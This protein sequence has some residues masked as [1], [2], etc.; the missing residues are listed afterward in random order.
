MKLYS[1]AALF[2][3]SLPPKC[4]GGLRVPETHEA[5]QALKNRE[6]ESPS[7]EPK[8]LAAPSPCEPGRAY[9]EGTCI[10]EFVK[11]VPKLTQD[12]IKRVMDWIKYKV[13]QVKNPFCW[14]GAYN[15]GPGVGG[16]TCSVSRERI[17]DLCYPTCPSGYVRSGVDC[18]QTCPS[19]FNDAGLACN[20]K[21]DGY[22]RWVYALWESQRCGNENPQGCEQC[23]LSYVPK[24]KPGFQPS[25]AC[26]WCDITPPNC[27]SYGLN[28]GIGI[29]CLKKV[30]LNGLS[31]TPLT[32]TANQSNYLGSCFAPC[33]ATHPVGFFDWCGVVCSPDQYDCGL[34]CAK[35]SS[36]CQRATADAIIGP[37]VFALNVASLGLGIP[38]GDVA[39]IVFKNI[40]GVKQT[41]AGLTQLGIALVDS[42]KK[43]EAIIPPER[44]KLVTNFRDPK[45]YEIVET[46]EEIRDV[47][48]PFYEALNLYHNSFADDFARLTSA[49][50]NSELDKRYHPSVTRF[51]KTTWASVDFKEMAAANT[52]AIVDEALKFLAA[53]P[54]DF[55]GLA[56]VVRAY[57]KPICD[58]FLPFP[59]ISA[60]LNVCVAKSLL[61]S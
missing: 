22:E 36:T 27:A 43:L 31:F 47:A 21:G 32:C 20:K 6:L 49:V 50:I 38:I 42:V 19:D 57:A 25:W 56:R 16:S 8:P 48:V 17:G 10:R 37:I 60:E 15:R 14:K 5:I 3:A 2:L 26:N 45:T 4:E 7:S 44:V 40:D 18:A 61:R 12:E 9:I 39:T 33:N 54:I 30:L 34:A 35:D 51:L 1:L 58:A 59:C 13:T 52:W 24:C 28:N 55:L 41:V 53:P 23:L 11:D 46:I 29:S